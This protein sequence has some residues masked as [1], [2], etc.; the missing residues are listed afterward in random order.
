[1]IVPPPQSGFAQ[2]QPTVI[3]QTI[4]GHQSNKSSLI[5]YLIQLTIGASFC[6][7]TYMVLINVLPDAAKAMLPVTTSVFNRAV[8]TLG[9]GILAVKETLTEQILGLSKKQDELSDKQ[10]DTHIE[11]LKVKDS[12]TDIR[13]DI[14]LVQHSLDLCHESMSENELRT[15]YIARG[16]RLLSRGV[17]SILPQDHDLAYELDQFNR[18]GESYQEARPRPMVVQLVSTRKKEDVEQE[19]QLPAIAAEA[20]SS[21]SSNNVETDPENEVPSTPE[22][23]NQNLDDVRLLLS[24]TA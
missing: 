9:R 7:G 16:M 22:G 11:V 17:S 19:N 23:N 18:E 15:T 20:S 1:M 14:G 13:T 3:Y 21:S 2:Q 4:P 24:G 12:V 5:M 10:D 8:K 6:W